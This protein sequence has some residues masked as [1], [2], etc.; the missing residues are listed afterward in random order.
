MS[1]TPESSKPEILLA[2][3]FG[4]RRIGV[5]VGQQVTD[6]A[7]P[8]GTVS[9]GSAGPDWRQ[10]T[11]WVADWRPSRLIV[12]LPLY[13]DGTHSV[14]STA[15]LAFI[16]ELGRFG[17]PIETIDERY[18]SAEAREMLKKERESGR[19]GRIRK[20]MIDSTAAVLIAERWF[21]RKT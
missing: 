4:Q 8:L 11:A 13:A 9:N 1:D 21:A 14:I 7:N 3:D 12:G 15:A 19:R 10:I 5:A 6:S 20:E 18:S 2:F 17:L 16:D